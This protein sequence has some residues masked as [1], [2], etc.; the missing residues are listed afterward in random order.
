MNLYITAYAKKKMGYYVSQ[1]PD[2]ISGLGKVTAVKAAGGETQFIVHDLEIFDQV[3]SSAH[4]TI[5]QE[6]LAKFLFDKMKAGEKKLS[7]YRFWWHSHAAM[8]VFFS[9]T[10][11]GTIDASTEFPWLISLVTNHKH[12]MKARFDLFDPIRHKVEDLN[13]IT[14][15]G[16]DLELKDLCKKE[17]TEKV[18]TRQSSGYNYD[19]KKREKGWGKKWWERNYPGE[20]ADDE[21]DETV[22]RYFHHGEN[23]DGVPARQEDLEDDTH[24]VVLIGKDKGKYSR[25]K[26]KGK[27]QSR[28]LASGTLGPKQQ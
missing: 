16:E 8:S 3:V 12:E 24:E 18:K 26:K 20:Q 6:T 17:I 15:E 19:G 22:S 14:L 2:E 4:S 11:T 21:D 7:E 1:C 13:I 28:L 9:G 25:H 23:S 27:Y 5:E 10:D